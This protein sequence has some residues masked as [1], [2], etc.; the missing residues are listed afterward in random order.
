MSAT[1]KV[2]SHASRKS[3]PNIRK[4]STRSSP[5]LPIPLV[6]K[7]RGRPPEASKAQLPTPI[8]QLSFTEL[9]KQMA[10]LGDG[11]TI[12]EKSSAA[13]ATAVVS[14]VTITPKKRGR[15]PKAA[16]AEAVIVDPS[17][18]IQG[19]IKPYDP[20]ESMEGDAVDLPAAVEKPEAQAL[21]TIH[22]MKA[23]ENEIVFNEDTTEGEVDPIGTSMTAEVSTVVST[24]L[25][26]SVESIE[27]LQVFQHIPPQQL[28]CEG[29]GGFRADFDEKVE[30]LSSSSRLKECCVQEEVL[31][32]VHYLI[33]INEWTNISTNVLNQLLGCSSGKY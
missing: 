3:P 17:G 10:L 23:N 2:F 1:K 28:K 9:Q 11:P 22:F 5:P 30:R 24:G 20:H 16:K 25:L 27:N 7:K 26:E 14:A 31:D 29:V 19:R 8:R 15:K 6:T 12:K 33:Y 4:V 32:E 18:L 13:A 21:D